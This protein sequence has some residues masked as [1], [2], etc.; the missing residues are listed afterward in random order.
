V[1]HVV[2]ELADA[3]RLG[4][5]AL[6]RLDPILR[7]YDPALVATGPGARPAAVPATEQPEGASECTVWADAV[8]QG[9]DALARRDGD[10]WII[11][12]ED[13][14]LNRLTGQRP[15]EERRAGV[16]AGV[17]LGR[18]ARKG[19]EEEFPFS[20]VMWKLAAE[21]PEL[22]VDSKPMPLLLRHRA[23]TY[24]SG[25]ENWLALNPSVGLDL[26]W[27]VQEEGLFRW[28]DGTG[29]VMAES[30]WWA[31]GL[32]AHSSVHVDGEVGEGWLVAVHPLA[33]AQVVERYGGLE[34][35]I[36]VARR[37]GTPEVER[38][39]RRTIY[40]PLV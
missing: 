32:A 21:Y 3:G 23:Y 22:R 28:A 18:L 4:P 31:D 1:F 33:Y 24:D 20:D 26:G 25:G 10:G 11:L 36:E 37:L 40:L 9:L 30:R 7:F 17:G 15:V 29:R 6:R 13:T 38:R 12:G 34:V 35:R 39:S 8:A 16:W 14:R 5:E 19:D 2:A 27:M